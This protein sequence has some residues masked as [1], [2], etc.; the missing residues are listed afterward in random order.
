MCHQPNRR[1]TSHPLWVVKSVAHCIKSFTSF[2]IVLD[3]WITNHPGPLD[4]PI[5]CFTHR[6]RP[7]FEV[8]NWAKSF[9][10]NFKPIKTVYLSTMTQNVIAGRKYGGSY[11]VQRWHYR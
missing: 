4:L 1:D 10:E 6:A 11:R 8:V 3:T 2:Q 5:F 9:N 7:L